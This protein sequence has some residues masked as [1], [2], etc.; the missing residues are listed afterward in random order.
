M[1]ATATITA[2][3]TRRPESKSATK[4]LWKTGTVTGVAAS[5]ATAAFAGIASAIDVAL[6]VG[7]KAIPV[8]GFAQVTFAAAIIGTVLAVVL[9][10]RANRPRHTFLV[11]TLALTFVSFVPDALADAH[12]ATKVTLALSHVLAAAIVIPA[13][14]SR[15]SD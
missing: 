15:L 3:A 9:A 11:T 10:R 13:L 4:S 8:I 2:P 7:G 12:T 14:A 5:V 1:T 6:E